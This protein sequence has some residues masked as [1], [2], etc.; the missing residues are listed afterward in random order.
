MSSRKRGSGRHKK[1]EQVKAAPKVGKTWESIV[2]ASLEIQKSLDHT[3]L[4]AWIPTDLCRPGSEVRDPEEHHIVGFMQRLKGAGFHGDKHIVVWVDVDRKGLSEAEYNVEKKRLVKYFVNVAKEAKLEYKE[5][6]KLLTTQVVSCK[7][8]H[9]WLASQATLVF[10]VVDGW[11]R[12]LALTRLAS[13][14]H[15]LT[16]VCWSFVYERN[17]WY[18]LIIHFLQPHRL[19]S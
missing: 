19:L 15:N 4:G 2:E 14:T 8:D 12:V 18:V 16:P 1:N 17:C 3:Y 13:T 5:D 6:S 7:I 9:T 10:G 11:H